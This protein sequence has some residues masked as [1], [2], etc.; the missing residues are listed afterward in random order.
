[1]SLV[2]LAKIHFQIATA[3][4]A[5]VIFSTGTLCLNG[6]T[7]TKKDGAGNLN[8]KQS[9]IGNRV[10]GS[11]DIALWDANVTTAT[12]V[13]L[14]GN[15]SWLGLRITNPGGSVTFNSGYTLTLGSSGI[16]MSSATVNLTLN[17]GVS[18]GST[19]I[20]NIAS[21]RTLL[22]SN[23]VSGSGGITKNGLG[24]VTLTG[25]N[26]FSGAITINAGTLSAATASALGSGTSALV[27]NPTGIL[28]ATG[29][30]STARAVT[31]GGT[32]GASSGGTL[33]VTAA[34]N[35][36][37]TGVVSGTGSLTKSG[38]G[39]LTLS[40]ANTYTG[41]TYINGG[42]VSATNSQALGALPPSLGT[43]LYGVHMASGTALQTT[44]STTGDNRQLQLVSGTATLDVTAAVSQQRNGL[45]YGSGGLIKTGAGT[46]I[47]TNANTYTGGTTING[48]VLQVNN[49]S[50]SATGTGAVTVNSG[51]TLSGLPTAVGFANAGTISGNVTV[52][53]GGILLA[54]S[55]ATLTLGGLTLNASATTN[56]QLGSLTSAP[57]I[58]ITGSNAFTLGGL[59]TIN[60]T[61]A[62]GL[63]VGTYRLFDY[64]GT[65]LASIANLQLNS[66]PGGGFTYSLSNNQTNTSID[67]IVSVTNQQWGNDAD[68]NWGA[69]SNWTSGAYANGVS[70]QANFLNIINQARTVT[71]NN[72]YT[73]GTMTFNNANSYTIASD[74]NATHILTINNNG[75]G[76]IGVTAGNHT[77]SAPLKL[78]DN[79]EITP[80]AG[81][82]LTIS[83]VITENSAGRTVTLDGAGN[84]TFSG[85]S[86]N[87]YTGLTTV[88]SGNL[89]LNK[90]A[91]V[92]A[93]GTGGIE[94]DSGATATWLAS[95]QISDTATVTANG[96]VA[97]GIFS[98][99]VGVLS[100]SGGVTV[101]SG[102]VFTIGGSNNL[103]STFTGIISGNGTIAKS[104]TGTLELTGANTFGG[105]GQTV[106]VNSGTL[107]ISSNGNLGN[108]SNGL[109]FNGGRLLLSADVTSARSVVLASG[110]TF[111]IDAN[112]G[113]FNGTIS[114]VG[115]LTKTG[116]GSLALSGTNTYSG[117]T[118]INNGTVVV[119]NAN[120][121]GAAGG[122]L[123][124]NAGTL[125]V[126]TG[127]A[128]SRNIVL[129]NASST[130]QVDPSQTYNASGI[131]SGTGT[132]NKT[133]TGNLTLTGA[134]TFT[135]ST[136]VTEGTLTL[137]SSS[138]TALGS[139]TGITVNAGGTLLLGASNQIGNSTGITL[140]AGTF[141]K[142]NFT[143]GLA[144]SSGLGAL[145]L[146][147]AGS[148]IDFGTGTVGVLSF[149]GFDPSVDALSITIDNWTG[150][151][152]TVGGVGTDRLI[153]NSSQSGNLSLFE[154]TGYAPGATQ[155]NLSGGFYEVVPVAPVP[156]PSTWIGAG[157]AGGLIGFNIVRRRRKN[158]VQLGSSTGELCLPSGTGVAS[159]VVQ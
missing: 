95:N 21:G 129:G 74:G 28:Q 119:N 13:G 136:A 134:N 87:S 151:A 145:T 143:E 102:S 67:L 153:F 112:A 34:N 71:V 23:V 52:N 42:T 25:S 152:N 26:T 10:P 149:A 35:E 127:F 38:T 117:G 131:V 150:T 68:G 19:Q 60:L 65:A 8:R 92:D 142:G 49:S 7:I 78:V 43:S 4:I 140:D 90:T 144:N 108:T 48:G 121:L 125:E 17:C 158:R 47:L 61:N 97:L 41:D 6:A 70:A 3:A 39:T 128:S 33:D 157:L 88:S 159:L 110:A 9:W 59:S 116:S 147:A 155:I 91:G 96:T 115:G 50:G 56:F 30:F 66:T 63:A 139:T 132:L 76:V 24:T 69:N 5:A 22:A 124:L 122:T 40:A 20:W 73:I 62:G 12:A 86:A 114:G 32:G 123:A 104:G 98:E 156:E 55:G 107:S 77:I 101:G 64:S 36:T 89:N 15:V 135:G 27:I 130:I 79:L 11:G 2:R 31:L 44:F 81:A 14:G 72:A 82:G 137:A 85:A 105:A 113:T 94:V 106:T 53:S 51:G 154:F 118:T 141:A 99:T 29:T 120:S 138:G 100:G 1:M 111:D 83:G 133:G 148:H 54:R 58:N 80:A 146:S 16:D 37:R 109:T 45:I 93:I 126:A 46:E 84:V 18:L 57:V 75:L 103:S